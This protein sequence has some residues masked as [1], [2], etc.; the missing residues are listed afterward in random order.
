[1]GGAAGPIAAAPPAVYP[2]PMPATNARLAL[3]RAIKAGEDRDYE[4]AVELLQ[5]LVAETDAAPEAYLYLGRSYHALGEW[6]KSI[7]ALRLYVRAGGDRAAGFFFLGRAYLAAGRADEAVAFLK[8]SAE[9]DSGRAQTWALLGAALLKERRSKAATGCLERAVGLAPGDRRIF[10]GYLNALFV[11]S[12]RLLSRGEADMARQMLSFAIANGLEGPGPRLWRARA[13]R[14]LGR[15]P[16]AIA[17]CEAALRQ[18]PGDAS[19]RWLRAGLLLSAGRGDEALDE[20]EALRADHP[21][22]PGIPRDEKALGRLRA[23]IAFREERWSEALA[24]SLAMLRAEPA[25]PALRAMAAESLRALGQMERARDH[26]ERAVEADPDEACFRLGLA[27]VLWELGDYQG[28]RA[29]VERARRLGADPGEVEYYA[30]LCD[31]RLGAAPETLAPRIQA[32]IRARGA[33]PRLM[34]ALGEVLYRSGRPDLAGGWFEK[35]L[36]LVPDHELSLLYR[37]SVAE[38]LGDEEALAAAYE[39]YLEAYP[40]ND[41]LRREYVDRLFSGGR[42][43]EAAAA[44]EDG[45]PYGMGGE[46]DRRRLALAY[47]NAGR[48]REAA[49]L[50]RDLLRASPSSPELLL[51][52]ALCL[53][54]DGK[55]DYALALLEK[56]PSTAKEG[57]AP[58]IVLGLLYS[59]RGRTEA[60]VDSLRKA[61]DIE[62]GNP[63]AWR[64]L[65]RIYERQGLSEFAARAYERADSLSPRTSAR[66]TGGGDIPRPAKAPAAR[67]KAAANKTAAAAAARKSAASAKA[68]APAAATRKGAA[69][70]K[71]AGAGKA[72]RPAAAAGATKAAPESPAE[73]SARK[74]RA[75]PAAKPDSAAKPSGGRTGGAAPGSRGKARR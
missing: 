41:K 67:G 71:P 40:D 55:G 4:K 29:T 35:V 1:M 48:F 25:D 19:L 21:E 12:A 18:A 33:D 70:G 13:F 54:R 30:A 6:G 57:A 58:W 51:S 11:R 22:L 14:E 73:A 28:A 66:Q 43:Q 23:S 50:Y 52:L 46:R 27:L 36:Y 39:A 62:P 9:A 38:S 69:G 64:D 8:R 59:R 32:L 34:F 37:A 61:T 3:E 74:P 49:I 53:E 31:A 20:F 68:A 42:W 63:R 56:A 10:H 45:L 15:F 44:L 2:W 65:G 16:E 24:E 5:A 60:A 17:D 75:R 7:E 26:W 47:R 72:S